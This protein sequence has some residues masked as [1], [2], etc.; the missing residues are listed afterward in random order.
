MPATLPDVRIGD[1]IRHDA[2]TV[3]PLYSS[4]EATV[5]YVL[6][7]EA[8][9]AGAV[10]VQEVSEGGS[11][12]NLLVKNEGGTR[13]LFLE[14]EELR[15]AKQNRILNTS[16]LI[17]AGSTAS[18]PV[19][20][21]EQGRWRYLGRH[22]APSGSHSSPTMRGQLK[23]SVIR[24]LFA[25]RGHVSDQGAVW[26]EVS[27]HMTSMGSASPTMAMSDMYDSYATHLAE[28]RQRLGY[29]EGATG[30]AVAIG[31]QVVALDVFDKPATCH[32]V[33]DRLLGG[34]VMNALEA[35][36]TDETVQVKEVEGLLGRLRG[37]TWEPYPAVGEGQEFRAADGN[38]LHASALVLENAWV[39]GSAIL[40]A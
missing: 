11:V 37:A 33:W 5:E 21:V 22:L 39:H 34:V 24:S 10:T 40:T 6:S 8:I 25:G 32:K 14:G 9:A 15:G 16:V 28:F 3:F 20:C 31:Q 17:A 1:P 38:V 26:G 13:V 36:P 7:D 29:V 19:S 35:K 30:L 2:L 18:I 23:R 4:N 27:R 12:P